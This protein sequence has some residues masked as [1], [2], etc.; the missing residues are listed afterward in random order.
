MTRRDRTRDARP[1]RTAAG[2]RRFRRRTLLRALAGGGAALALAP[3]PLRHAL[4]SSGELRML[5]WSDYLPPALT[6]GF[7]AKTG[8]RIRHFKYGS[9]EELLSKLKTTKGR[10]YDL[11]G[12]TVLRAPQWRPLGLLQPFDEKRLPSGRI[13]TLMMALSEAQWAWQGGLHHLPY[14]WGTEALAWRSDKWT[15]EA[16]GPSYG[17]LWRPELKGLVMGRPHSMMLGIGLYLD[18]AGKL[19]SNRMLDAYKDEDSMRRIWGE[20]TAFAVDHRKWVHLFW[21]DSETQQNG[22]LKNDIVLG[23][24]WDG[25]AAALRRAGEPIRYMAPK[26]GAL[27]WLDGLAMPKGAV[28]V[29]QAYAFLDYI[30]SPEIGALIANETGYNTV[31]VG[32]E[33]HLTPLTKRMFRDAYPGTAL[34]NLWWWPP[35]PIWYAQ[36]RNGFRDRFLAG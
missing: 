31:A 12:P 28:N 24:T 16:D 21:N 7:Q 8:I 35:E 11:V 26:E 13:E 19:P 18:A 15:P 29:E 1:H 17:D 22:F 23:Q 3:L 2:A 4:A 32:A 5:F 33:A 9:N 27:A 34:Q 20:I 25:P 36:L 14:L 30:Y 6:A 10:G